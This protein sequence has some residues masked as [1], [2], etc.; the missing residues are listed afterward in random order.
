[1]TTLKTVRS[2][3]IKLLAD[4][5]VDRPFGSVPKTVLIEKEPDFRDR[6]PPAHS[7]TIANSFLCL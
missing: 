2:I 6:K 1:M 3:V 4:V 5:K 7:S